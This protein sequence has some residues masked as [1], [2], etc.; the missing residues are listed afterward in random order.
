VVTLEGFLAAVARI[1]GSCVE[2]ADGNVKV[3]FSDRRDRK[4]QEPRQK[5]AS[6]PPAAAQPHKSRAMLRREQRQRQVQRQQQQQQP[7]E[8]QAEQPDQHATEQ[9]NEQ[10][11]GFRPAAADEAAVDAWLDSVAMGADQQRELNAAARAS[12]FAAAAAASLR[13]ALDDVAIADVASDRR[14]AATDSGK[15]QAAVRM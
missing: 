1:P 13:A 5:P 15:R 2:Y 14:A 8:P 10:L 3:S 9:H 12:G 6:G 11:A 4:V 7:P